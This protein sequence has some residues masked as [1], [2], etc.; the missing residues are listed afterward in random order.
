MKPHTIKALK[1]VATF[2]FKKISHPCGLMTVV[3]GRLHNPRYV[4][5]CDIK[6]KYEKCEGCIHNG[7]T[8]LPPEI[9]IEV[10]E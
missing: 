8:N 3:E 2:I 4:T 6:G 10:D 7:G 9:R 5:Y 1:A